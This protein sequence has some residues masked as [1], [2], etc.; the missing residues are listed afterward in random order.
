VTAAHNEER[1]VEQVIKSVVDQR[2]RPV[3]WVIVSD[4]STDGTGEIVQEYALQYE[5]IRLHRMTGDHPRNFTAQVHA[6]NAGFGLLREMEC[7]LIGN[8]DADITLDPDYF[9]RLVEKFRAEPRLGLAGGYIH[10]MR[11][12]RFVV[13]RANN[14]SSVAHGVQLFRRKCLE[15]IGGGYEPLPFGGPDWYAEIRARMGN[16]EVKAF[17][18]LKVYHHRL[19]SSA[20]G[21]PRNWY[22]HGLLHY[23]FGSHPVFEMCKALR[24]VNC[25]PYVLGAAVMFWAFI[26]AHA[27]REKHCLPPEMIEYLRKEQVSR[28]TNCCLM[29]RTGQ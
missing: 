12:G 3:R 8:L 10:E 20:E 28:L 19:T 24:R 1:Y 14:P 26:W 29:F 18:D 6:I 17:P 7:E 21:F 2:H 15:D 27:R 4:G 23:S 16:W 22:R 11:R 9:S 5:F 25:R 13:R